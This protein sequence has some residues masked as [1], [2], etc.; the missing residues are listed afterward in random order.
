MLKHLLVVTGAALV[1]TGCSA[2]VERVGGEAA[3]AVAPSP[4]A[5]IA[6]PSPT[7]SASAEP[8]TAPTTRPPASPA[9]PCPVTNKTLQKALAAHPDDGVFPD[10]TFTK[11]VCFEGYAATTVPERSNS[12]ESYVVWKHASGSWTVLSSGT[13]DICPGVPADVIKHFRSARYGACG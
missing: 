11:I 1:L 2:G 12:D 4:S 6:A 9:G 8:T 13:A 5:T 10:S 7:P 3:P